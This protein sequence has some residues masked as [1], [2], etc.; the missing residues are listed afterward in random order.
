MMF[1]ENRTN[2]L[3]SDTEFVAPLGRVR[4]GEH[5][6][7]TRATALPHRDR[8]HTVIARL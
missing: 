3:A 4:R 1:Y 6:S 2:T 5:S 7:L 8:P